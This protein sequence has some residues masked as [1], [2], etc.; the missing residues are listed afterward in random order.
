MLILQR[1][2]GICSYGDG[3][4]VKEAV[5]IGVIPSNVK[6]EKTGKAAFYQNFRL[7]PDFPSADIQFFLSDAL[8][9]SIDMILFPWTRR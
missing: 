4:L 3:R 8:R 1:D 6:Y 9:H 5:D 2:G 7:P